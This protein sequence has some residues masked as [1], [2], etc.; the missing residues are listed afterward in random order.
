VELIHVECRREE[1]EGRL[2]RVR[3]KPGKLLSAEDLRASGADRTLLRVAACTHA[4]SSSASLELVREVEKASMEDREVRL[5]GRQVV[6]RTDTVVNR[7][8]V[9]GPGQHTATTSSGGSETV[10]LP[11]TFVHPGPSTGEGFE[12]Y[13]PARGKGDGTWLVDERFFPARGRELGWRLDLDKA[14]PSPTELVQA[15]STLDVDVEGPFVRLAV[16]ANRIYV[17]VANHDKPGALRIERDLSTLR[18][19]VARWPDSANRRYL[20]MYADDLLTKL[21]GLARSDVSLVDPCGG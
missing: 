16:Y 8:F 15:M 21:A 18:E 6:V 2:Q 5:A 1:D 11:S 14:D 19:G 20:L 12:A 3:C 9:H 13:V 17:A 7:S 10:A 4:S